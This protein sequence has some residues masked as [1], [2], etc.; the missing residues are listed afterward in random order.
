MADLVEVSKRPPSLHLHAVSPANVTARH[1]GEA[2]SR[3]TDLI[4]G[5]CWKWPRPN[6]GP[7][8]GPLRLD[9]R[10]LAGAALKQRFTFRPG[11]LRCFFRTTSS[12]N[13][14]KYFFPRSPGSW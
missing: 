1:I 9:G 10:W 6:L 5:R 12:R 4:T 14:T 2:V 8:A 11:Q 13:T 3:L 7:A